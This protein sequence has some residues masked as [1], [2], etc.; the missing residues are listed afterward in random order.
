MFVDFAAELEELADT[1]DA[2]LLEV[3]GEPVDLQ[4]YYHAPRSH[5]DDV[6]RPSPTWNAALERLAAADV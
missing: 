1:I 4:G 3:Q 6:M 2:E 5:L